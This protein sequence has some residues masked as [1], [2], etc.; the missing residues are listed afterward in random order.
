MAKDSRKTVLSFCMQFFFL[1]VT[2]CFWVLTTTGVSFSIL[3]NIFVLHRSCYQWWFD[4]TN[5]YSQKLNTRNRNILSLDSF[6]L[7]TD[8]FFFS[9]VWLVVLWKDWG[10]L[11][12]ILINL[13]FTLCTLQFFILSTFT[14][15]CKY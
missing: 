9:L 7:F 3:L 14:N 15:F 10:N 12:T 13:I 8:F 4:T 6:Q 5:L 2:F 1:W 11:K